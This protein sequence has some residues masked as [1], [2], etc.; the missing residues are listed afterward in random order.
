MGRKSNLFLEAVGS[1]IIYVAIVL[2]TA[3][4]FQWC[5]DSIFGISSPFIPNL[6]FVVLFVNNYKK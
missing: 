5:V 6:V 3:V 4:S 2:L 1:V